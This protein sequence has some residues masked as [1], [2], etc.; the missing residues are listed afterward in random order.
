MN[1]A[2]EVK[3]LTK[4]YGD[5]KAVDGISF[6][7]RAGEI[8]G[9]LGP[10]GAGKTTTVECLQGLRES[11]SGEVRLLGV[12]NATQN[13]A[14]RARLGIQFQSTGLLPN[15]KVREQVSLFRNLYPKTLL[16]DD[17]LEMVGLVEKA[18]T[19]TKSLSGGQ[20][21]RLAVAL[22]LVNDPDLIFLDEPTTGLDPQARRNLWEVVLGLKS[23]GKTILL[24]TH[25][26]E[27]AETLC[28]RVA[29]MDQGAIIELDAPAELRRRYF[30]ETAI[31]FQAVNGGVPIGYTGL[32]GVTEVLRENGHITLYSVDV[33]RTMAGLFNQGV[34]Q[35][36]HFNGMVIR[37]AT[38][39]DVFLK[40]TGRRIRS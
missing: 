40:L 27:E 26:M 10:N 20:K 14:V 24:T 11:D 21:Q 23:Q 9:L 1:A 3:D 29:V 6:D 25:Y 22:A 18:S 15:Q 33:P 37:Q 8:F 35:H 39:E 16:V 36:L 4:S 28:D 31:E 5:V 7:V 2:I 12:E 17:V 34:D 38:L 13:Q 30:K 19:A 32:P